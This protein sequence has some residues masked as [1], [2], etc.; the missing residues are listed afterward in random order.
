MDFDYHFY[1][2]FHWVP[3]FSY[4]RVEKWNAKWVKNQYGGY[5]L[6]PIDKAY[7]LHY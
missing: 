2:D 5:L 4:L 3:K 7:K 6:N 1:V